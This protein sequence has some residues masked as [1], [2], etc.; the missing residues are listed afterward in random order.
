MPLY[1]ADCWMSGPGRVLFG[2]EYERWSKRYIEFMEECTELA[3]IANVK[4]ITAPKEWADF[5]PIL[6][7]KSVT[8]LISVF[9]NDKAAGLI[10][11]AK[12]SI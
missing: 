5:Q 7:I 10:P 11:L 9:N 6:N 1:H 4:S 12:L 8:E 3:R 2:E